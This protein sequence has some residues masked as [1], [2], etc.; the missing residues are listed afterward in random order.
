MVLPL[1]VRDYSG[2]CSTISIQN[3]NTTASAV[4]TVEF[5]RTGES[6]ATMTRD[7]TIRR[8]TSVTLRTCEDPELTAYLPPGFLGSMRVRSR[9]GST[10]FAVSSFVTLTRPGQEKAVYAF[11]GVPIENGA[12][13][14]YAP[15]FRKRQA[16]SGGAV[17]VTGISVLNTQ[18]SSADV[19]V[20][21]HPVVTAACPSGDPV[22]EQRQLAGASS[23]VFYQGVGP[24]RDGCYGS[25]RITSDER[26]LAVV[27]DSVNRGGVNNT[28]AAAYNAFAP[29]RAGTLV[30]VPLFRSGH[31][32]AYL[33]TAIS[34][35]NT[36]AQPAT[37]TL[38]AQAAD[39]TVL[40]GQPGMT[41]T[42][43]LPN[44]VVVFW[45]PDFTKRAG[46]PWN[47]GTQA[48]G[49]ATVE[50]TPPEYAMTTR[51]SFARIAARR[52]SLSRAVGFVIGVSCPGPRPQL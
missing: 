27:N 50:S 10:K 5:R 21:Y 35:L 33:F 1:A 25:A 52:A 23:V 38:R 34:A 41:K 2:Q 3:T 48:Y 40:E 49:S 8:G 47:A 16:L 36:G 31:S 15:L 44:Q 12:T 7:Y 22:T 17:G 32:K 46:W 29:D 45:P 19:T 4:A 28:E 9:D 26:I 14:L 18:G 42:N 37:I 13:T 6:V 30:A 51:P 39:G 11:E 20:E 24:V 43:V